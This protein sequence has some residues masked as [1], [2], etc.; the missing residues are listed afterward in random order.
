MSKRKVGICKLTGKKGEFVKSHIIP[1]AFT[2]PV[3]KGEYF[4]QF[5]ETHKRS[6]KRWSSWYDDHLVVREGEDILSELDDFAVKELSKYYLVWRSWDGSIM[7]PDISWT[8]DIGRDVDDKGEEIFRVITGIDQ[9]KLRLFCLSLLWRAASSDLLEMS[10]II[11][12]EDDLEFIR[13]LL[14]NRDSGLFSFYPVSLIQ[15]STLG[16]AHNHTPIKITLEEYNKDIYRFYFNGLIIHFHLNL[17]LKYTIDK[18]YSI[19]LCD[20][21][22]LIVLLIDYNN[23]FQK[24]N[25][26]L[27]NFEYDIQHQPKFKFESE[28]FSDFLIKYT[29]YT[30]H[31]MF[32]KTSIC[33][34]QINEELMM[35]YFALSIK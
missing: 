1:Q 12:P 16:T 3:P 11:L 20:S 29:F 22:K 21:N 14:I 28:F 34:A 4:I 13:K 32:L 9:N 17:E 10:D 27:A 8:G 7:L 26:R 25:L 6:I 5:G 19:F 18:D 31:S 35:F 24:D 2:R 23:S 30:K 33:P 15:L